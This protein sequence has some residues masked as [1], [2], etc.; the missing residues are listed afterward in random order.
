MAAITITLCSQTIAV[1]QLQLM[2]TG[3]EKLHIKAR[4]LY[5]DCEIP[6]EWTN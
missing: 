3:V 2:R 6:G 4:K 5:W 1:N